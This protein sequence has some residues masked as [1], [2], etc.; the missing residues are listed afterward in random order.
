MH[1]FVRAAIAVSVG[2]GALFALVRL[3]VR[4][5]MTNPVIV[6][7]EWVV[8]F[9][10]VPSVTVLTYGLLTRHYYRHNRPDG[11]TGCRRCG[12]ILRGL[13]EPQCSEC[14]EGI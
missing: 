4:V 12:Y 2:A 7:A 14:G 13:T 8:L 5:P 6:F 9:G 10:G 1:W 3:S 11:E